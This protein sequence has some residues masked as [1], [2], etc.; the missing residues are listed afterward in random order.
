M[1]APVL[2][3]S[4]PRPTVLVVDDE[5]GVLEVLGYSLRREGFEVE[6]CAS[7]LSGMRALD[8]RPFDLLILDIMLPDGNGFELC[9]RLRAGSR[10]PVLFLTS[11]DEEADRIVGLEIGGDDY[12]TKPFS[13]R[14]VA[15]RVRAILRR[16]TGTEAPGARPAV[17]PADAPAGRSLP[18][19]PVTVSGPFLID[20]DR[21]EVRYRGHLLALSRAE[22]SVLDVLLR[23]PGR[24]FTR[25]N[26]LDLAW[27]GEAAVGDRTIDAHIKGLRRKIRLVDGSFDAI[28]TVRGVGYRLRE[29]S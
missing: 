3:A 21:F 1:A 18:A 2:A 5:P 17:P 10:M 19:T 23:S 24:V 8:A 26:F 22:Y 14:E 11:R 16:T 25:E 13:P 20:P 4:P 6:C 28:E 29:V 15:A 9:R 12:V 7:A 27:G